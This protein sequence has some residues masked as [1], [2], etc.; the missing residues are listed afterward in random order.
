MFLY[1]YTCISDIYPDTE[2]ELLYDLLLFLTWRGSFLYKLWPSLS[3]F[4][5]AILFICKLI[6]RLIKKVGAENDKKNPVSEQRIQSNQNPSLKNKG[7]SKA[8]THLNR[9]PSIDL[10]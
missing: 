10:W 4:L 6:K 2:I 9:G 8:T 1:Q 3:I 7:E 5:A